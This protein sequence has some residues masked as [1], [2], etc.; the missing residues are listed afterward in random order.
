MNILVIRADGTYYARP[1]TTLERESKDFYLPDDCTGVCA[2]RFSFVRIVK[3][4]KAVGERFAGRYFSEC[5]EGVMLY[6]K[7]SL[8][9][10]IDCSTFISQEMHPLDD[11]M[12]QRFAESLSMVTRHTSVR[13][14]D[15]LCIEEAECRECAGGDCVYGISIL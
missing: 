2:R 10:Y 5:G 3:A 7:P 9:P 6:G 15:L 14:G 11:S 13:I 12:A 4:G 1:D 8:T